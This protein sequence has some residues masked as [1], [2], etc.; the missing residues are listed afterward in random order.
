MQSLPVL[1]GQHE[2]EQKINKQGILTESSCAESHVFRPFAKGNSGATTEV[3][4]KL[5]YK[6]ESTGIFTAD[7]EKC[8]FLEFI[9]T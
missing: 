5:V 3:K 2:C 7:G 1:K 4:T 9:L 8:Y 6:K